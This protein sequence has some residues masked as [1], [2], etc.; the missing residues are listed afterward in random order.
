MIRDTSSKDRSVETEWISDVSTLLSINVLVQ[1]KSITEITLSRL[2]DIATW[3]VT[4][5]CYSYPKARKK[6]SFIPIYLL[7]IAHMFL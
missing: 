2:Y 3:K 4:K 6:I 5:F 7:V 1:I